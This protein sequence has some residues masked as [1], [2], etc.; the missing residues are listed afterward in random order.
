QQPSAAS[1]PR[2]AGRAAAL[3]RRG[4]PRPPR[5]GPAGAAALGRRAGANG[6]VVSRA[7][8]DGGDSLTAR[9]RLDLRKSPD[10][11]SPFPRQQRPQRL[12]VEEELGFLEIAELGGRL[13]E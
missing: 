10:R 9:Q 7:G 3:L 5:A 13:G 12:A 1:R 8:G 4:W 11:L 2:Q 6:G